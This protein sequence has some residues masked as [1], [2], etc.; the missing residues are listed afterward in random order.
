ME[1]R[2]RRARLTPMSGELRATEDWARVEPIDAK[3]KKE[4]KRKPTPETTV[5]MLLYGLRRFVLYG[6]AFSAAVAG[7]AYLVS[8]LA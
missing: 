5:G 4:R 7:G 6:A 1:D 2:R 3:P 8:W